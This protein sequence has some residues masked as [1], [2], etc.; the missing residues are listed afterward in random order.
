MSCEAIAELDKTKPRVVTRRILIRFL[1]KIPTVD[2][3]T[4][5]STH[6]DTVLPAEGCVN[7]LN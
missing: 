5:V 3:A 7:I 2:C 6:K 1:L 4:S